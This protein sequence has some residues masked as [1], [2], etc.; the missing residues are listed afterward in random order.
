MRKINKLIV[1]CSD[2]PSKMDIGAKEIDRWH[3]ER[4]W[5]G[6]GYHFVVRRNG[7]VED[8]RP[9]KKIGAHVKGHNRHS[10]GICMVGRDKF[11][12]KQY[13]SL[14]KLIRSLKS[15]YKGIEVFG[16]RDFDNKKECP[17]FDV[18][19]WHSKEL[20]K[21]TERKKSSTIKNKDPDNFLIRS[22][23]KVIQFIKKLLNKG[24]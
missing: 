11:T 13:A 4:G 7:V 12:K 15:Q 8:G 16:H 23:N 20:K 6:I 22:F 2:T 3:K 9:V 18:R 14:L 24:V 19:G 1:H 10:I 5:S 21:L 17:C